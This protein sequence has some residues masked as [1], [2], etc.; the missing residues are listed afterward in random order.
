MESHCEEVDFVHLML[1][2]VYINVHDRSGA[3]TDL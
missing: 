1:Q 2:I 3:V